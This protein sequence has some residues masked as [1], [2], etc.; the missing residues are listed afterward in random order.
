MKGNT[1]SAQ[2]LEALDRL[3]RGACPP[4]ERA[5]LEARLER[6]PELYDQFKISKLLRYLFTQRREEMLQ[7]RERLRQESEVPPPQ[8]EISDESNAP[9]ADDSGQDTAPENRR[10][11][12]T[13]QPLP[14]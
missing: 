2:D 6:E 3:A 1:I 7:L 11:I 4:E 8:P 12:G 10:R 5:T 9:E 14:R 13:D